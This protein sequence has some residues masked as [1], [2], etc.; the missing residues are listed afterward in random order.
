MKKKKEKKIKIARKNSKFSLHD[1]FKV[2]QFRNSNANKKGTCSNWM[3]NWLFLN[4]LSNLT[5]REYI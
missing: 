3:G 1:I 5:L 2:M 4:G